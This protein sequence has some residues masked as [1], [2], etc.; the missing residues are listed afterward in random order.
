MTTFVSVDSGEGCSGGVH[1]QGHT[2]SPGGAM[3]R[4]YGRE[5]GG[6]GVRLAQRSE[7]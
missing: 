6:A 5:G 2:A 1:M 4:Q 3:F 7:L